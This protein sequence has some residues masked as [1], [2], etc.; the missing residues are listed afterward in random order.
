MRNFIITLFTFF[1]VNALG[2]TVSTFM[3]TNSFGCYGLTADTDYLYVVASFSGKVHR[4]TLSSNDPILYETYDIG[5]SGYNSICKTG[6]YIYLSKPYNG[7]TGI[8]R[9]DITD[10]AINLEYFF[11]QNN[12]FGIA[13]RDTELFYSSGTKLYKINLL[14]PTP[15]ASEIANISG[16]T[17]G[18]KVYG[19]F[20]YF[21]DQSGISKINL[22]SGN[23]ELEN[24]TTNLATNFALVSNDI[25]LT[26]GSDYSAIYKLDVL[27]QNSS[28]F[29]TI[30]NFIGTNDIL[31]SNNSL[32]V[33]TFEGDYDK[34]ARVTLNNLRLNDY[35]VKKNIYLYPNPAEN[36]IKVT[37]LIGNENISIFNQ[38]GQLINIKFENDE[39][40]VS[41]F[42]DGIYFMRIGEITYKFVKK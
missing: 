9:F 23:Y 19:N 21:S 30:D 28:L 8:H 37:G 29:A 42:P 34:V 14:S 12:I 2:Q 18:L 24:V 38:I 40:N 17:S 20:L 22:I 1:F 7:S 26:G 31:F 25:Y 13:V 35:L 41:N 6:N 10:T 3:D 33:T 39:L 36:Y 27:T 5:G 15:I 4:K 16:S 32:F 11:V